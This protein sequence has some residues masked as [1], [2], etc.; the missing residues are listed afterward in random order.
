MTSTLK[1]YYK[2][3]VGSAKRIGL[4]VA[5]ISTIFV[6]TG[7]ACLAGSNAFPRSHGLSLKHRKNGYH[8]FVR[9]QKHKRHRFFKN[10]HLRRHKHKFSSFGVLGGYYGRSDSYDNIQINLVLPPDKQEESSETIKEAREPLPPHIE[11][12]TE[13]NDNAV[14]SYQTVNSGNT[15]AHIVEYRAHRK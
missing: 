6:F 10:R 15:A 1:E 4:I 3:W 7:T 14:S 5:T 8:H 2:P 11:T 13:G 9:P 12:L